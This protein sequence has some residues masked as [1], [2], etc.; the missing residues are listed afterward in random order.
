VTSIGLDLVYLAPGATGGMETYARALIP[1]LARQRPGV[2]WVAF[3]GREL[4]SELRARPWAPNLEVVGLPMSSRRRV[5][6][7]AVEQALLPL[8]IRRAGVDL[9]HSLGNTAPL[10]PGGPPLVL[11]VHDLIWARVPETHRGV[12][13]KG[14]AFLVP[15][16]ASRAAA[17]IA[18]SRATAADVEQ[19]LGIPAER[20]HVVPSGPGAD[21]AGITPEGELRDRLGLGDRP[22]VLCPA[23][24]RPHKNVRRLVEATAGLDATLVVPGYAS[25]EESGLETAEHARYLDW[26]SDADM[27]GLYQAATLLAFPS[28]AEGFGLPVLEAMRRGLPVACSNAT[29]LP[30]IA[31]DA[32]LL[33]DPRDRG[34]MRD[35]VARLLDDAAL[36]DDLARRGREQAARFSWEAAGAATGRVY[37][38][39]AGT[40]ATSRPASFAL[41][42]RVAGLRLVLPATALALRARTVRRASV[43]AL[44]ELRGG[45]RIARYELREAP[46]R[47]LVRHGRGD[48]ATLGEV[49]HERHYVPP[50]DLAAGLDPVLILDLGANIGLFGA[51]ASARWE[52][53]RIVAYEPDPGN[54]TICRE[55]IEENGLEDRWELRRAAAASAPGQL[56]FNA[57]GDALS[58]ADEQ[59]ELVVDAHDVL[60]DIARADLVKIDIEGGEW[61]LLTD[62]RFAVQPPRALVIEYHPH[63]CPAP[64]PRELVEQLLRDAGMRRQVPIFHRADGHGM[65]WAWRA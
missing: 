24:R 23:P 25:Y 36:R 2:R 58:H 65:L 56:R 44:R 60:P 5:R 41:L 54:A 47:I 50:P 39:V 15:R 1:E 9:V 57:S 30:E 29:S 12:L 28:L 38:R 4:A 63:R 34:A 6:R 26:V 59:G 52:R 20:I 19:R 61:A 27:E 8:M 53:A 35:A 62:P 42:R 40:G 33:F 11:T 48:A 13:A 49:F 46:V 10:A 22:L 14:L 16:S 43:F 55:C 17:I 51:F 3:C 37:D 64:D 18:V 32:A 7:V 45:G 31:G 21:H